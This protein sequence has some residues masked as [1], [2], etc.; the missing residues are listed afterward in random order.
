M[1]QEPKPAGW[2]RPVPMD[3]INEPGP[4]KW[5]V[6]FRGIVIGRCASAEAAQAIALALQAEIDAAVE[7]T[8]LAERKQALEA[9]VSSIRGTMFPEG[10]SP[11]DARGMACAS[12]RKAWAWLATLT[13]AAIAERRRKAAAEEDP[14]S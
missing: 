7:E 5:G 13:P 2:D 3:M 9:A 4:W 1:T 11:N 8:A 14:D 10:L 6:G 12:V